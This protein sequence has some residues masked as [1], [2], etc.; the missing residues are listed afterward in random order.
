MRF[1]ELY[2]KQEQGQYMLPVLSHY[3]SRPK[4]CFKIFHTTAGE[5]AQRLRALAALPEALSSIP[6]NHMVAYNHL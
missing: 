5:M 3:L 2:R 6:S 4:A 1:R